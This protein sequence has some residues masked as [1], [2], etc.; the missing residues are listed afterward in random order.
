MRVPVVRWA[1]AL[2]VLGLGASAGCS[3]GG[4][5]GG[6]GGSSSGSGGGSTCHAGSCNGGLEE[7]CNEQ[8]CCQDYQGGFTASEGQSSCAALH[9]T[10]SPDP[11]RP[12]DLVG[13]CV[14]Y[15]GTV[16]QQT[17][18]YYAGYVI[19]DHEPGADSSEANCEGI[20]GDWVAP[21]SPGGTCTPGSS[22]GSGSSGG[23]SGSSSG[24]SGSGGDGGNGTFSCAGMNGTDLHCYEYKNV[25]PSELT[26]LMSSCTGTQGTG[27]PTADLVGCCTTS[28]M[29]GGLTLE[30]CYYPPITAASAQQGCSIQG[31]WSTQP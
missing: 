15:D 8:L 14:L 31:T 17:V 25:P 12:T 4:G 22:S 21:D 16:A 10:Y 9:G 11:C 5:G 18:R 23:G 1:V 3:P 26:V 6:G 20:N 27:C 2:V 29:S 28:Q 24:A 13:S 30:T 7:S 19:M